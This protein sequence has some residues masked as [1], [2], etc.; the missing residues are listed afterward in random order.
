M[1]AKL[2]KL[3]KLSIDK[4]QIIIIDG[5]SFDNLKYL[6][7]I[8]LQYN[9]LLNITNDKEI[10]WPKSLKTIDLSH[11]NLSDFHISIQFI[12]LIRFQMLLKYYLLNYI[13][14][15]ID[16]SSNKFT[17]FNIN[18]TKYDEFV[19][20]DFQSPP[21][22]L[23]IIND[24]PIIC[25]CN[26]IDLV[27]FLNKQTKPKTIYDHLNFKVNNLSCNEPKHFQDRL[28]SSLRT[29]D[30]VCNITKDCP[31]GCL[32]NQRPSDSTLIFKC[33]KL[34][35]FPTLPKY[36]NL[37]LT[38]TELHAANN[39]IKSIEVWNIPDDIKVLDLRN[40]SLHFIDDNVIERF[41]TIDQ[42]Y[43]SENRWICDCNAE[44]FMTFFNSFRS[45]IM[46]GDT[47]LCADGRLFKELN[48]K[49]LCSRFQTTELLVVLLLIILLFGLFLI[50]YLIYKKQIK[51][52]LYA[53]NC[54]LWWVSEAEA[55]KGKV[56]D[57]FFIFSHFDD[58]FVT[59]LI[60]D[61]ELPP[62]SFKCCVH[63]RD[64]PAGEMIVTLVRQ[65]RYFE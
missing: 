44:K 24:N 47:M 35:Q 29:S 25:D 30:L 22:L 65:Y 18:D 14:V 59:D 33:F 8:N 32:C 38:N 45:K 26:A 16:L 49:D 55:D 41:K 61:L 6:K 42:L 31:E 28:V 13:D 9:Q 43:L 15:E 48:P 53:H 36:V 3:E 2:E 5:N 40:N 34:D 62:N 52:W 63:H 12:S 64:W 23:M 1:F 60:L 46:D 39:S 11:N 57:A 37:N 51:M 27:Q 21:Q 7:V 20:F 19:T 17:E 10:S 58:S 56:Y 50:I 4:N 54:C